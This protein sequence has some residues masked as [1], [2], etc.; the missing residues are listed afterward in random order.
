MEQR[1][2]NQVK[3]VQTQFAHL[4]RFQMETKQER[5]TSI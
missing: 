1:K 2:R 3:G 4:E 5:E